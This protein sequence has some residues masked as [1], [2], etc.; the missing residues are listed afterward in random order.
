M[1]CATLVNIQTPSYTH[2]HTHGQHF[3]QPLCKAQLVKLKILIIKVSHAEV[4]LLWSLVIC[5]GGRD[6]IIADLLY[7]KLTL[8]NACWKSVL[9]KVFGYRRYIAVDNVIYI[10]VEIFETLISIA[11]AHSGTL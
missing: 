2:T 11:P 3:V 7:N 5:L 9:G 1:I 8:R 10:P 6:V 4:K